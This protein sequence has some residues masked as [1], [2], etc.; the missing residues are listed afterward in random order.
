MFTLKAGD[1]LR[2]FNSWVYFF[3]FLW[4]DSQGVGASLRAPRTSTNPCQRQR[5]TI[6]AGTIRFTRNLF[7]A[8]DPKNPTVVNCIVG[9]LSTCFVNLVNG[10]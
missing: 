6:H 4:F 9:V 5:Q 7:L 2:I 10:R 1:K 8:P 3:F